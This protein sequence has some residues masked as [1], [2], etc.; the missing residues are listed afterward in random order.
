MR[1]VHFCC[2]SNWTETPSI[3][4]E[5]LTNSVSLATDPSTLLT[6]TGLVSGVTYDAVLLAFDWEDT[7][8]RRLGLLDEFFCS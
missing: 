5:D 6:T 3:S 8:C 2:T 1:S 4:R 7:A